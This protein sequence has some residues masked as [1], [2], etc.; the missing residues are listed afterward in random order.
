MGSKPLRRS[1]VIFAATRTSSSTSSIILVLC[2]PHSQS[3]I[4]QARKKW[5]TERAQFLGKS[6]GKGNIYNDEVNCPSISPTMYEEFCAA[7]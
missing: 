6:V 1:H 7:L 3:F 2:P 4:T 5:T